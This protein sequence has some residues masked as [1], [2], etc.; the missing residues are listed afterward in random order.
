MRSFVISLQESSARLAEFRSA[1]RAAGLVSEVFPAVDGRQLTELPPHR[2]G[3][4]AGEIGCFLSHERLLRSIA[5]TE[6]EWVLI[7]EDDVLFWDNFSAE[8]ERAVA[9]AKRTTAGYVQLGW[10]PLTEGPDRLRLFRDRTLAVAPLR[11]VARLVRPRLRVEAPAVISAQLGWGTHCYMVRT[12]FACVVADFL[13][14][15]RIHAPIDHYTPALRKL[16]PE[17]IFRARFSLAGQRW[18]EASTTVSDRKLSLFQTDSTGH[19]RYGP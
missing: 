7:L 1:E 4:T 9:D 3:L 15:P 18:S 10:M 16:Y 11:R 8:L 2:V 5:S 13:G 19:V 17:Q 12:D 14:G 6:R